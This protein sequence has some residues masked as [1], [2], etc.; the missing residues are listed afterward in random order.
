MIILFA[1]QKGG[2]GKTTLAIA[3]ANYLVQIMNKVVHVYDF[4]SQ[5]SFFHKWSE[6]NACGSDA[7]MLYDVTVLE[8]SPFETWDH[9]L[10]WSESKEIYLVDL[11][12][13]LDVKYTDMLMYSDYIIIPF[14]YSDVSCKSTLIFVN[15][16]SKMGSEAEKIFLRS[17]YD[18]GFNY[19]NQPEMDEELSK[20][21]KIVSAPVYKRNDLQT[22]STRGLV[23][24]KTLAA[25]DNTF[26][27][28][29]TILNL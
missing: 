24:N 1:Q 3:F 9:A 16:L 19:P 10:R 17:R 4:D 5:K 8:E 20:Y 11:A 29:T 12:G 25:V 18:K 2:V 13:T 23:K 6:D 22:I 15:I 7:D 26:V 27:E 14:E 21:G 28:L